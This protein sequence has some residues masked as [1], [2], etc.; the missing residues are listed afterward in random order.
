MLAQPYLYCWCGNV[1]TQRS[2]VI[3]DALYATPWYE[4]DQRYKRTLC[5]AMECMKRPI[6]FKT[7]YYIPL[8]RP[9]FVSILR[10]SYS[11][12]AVL[13]QANNQ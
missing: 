5:I 8:S 2:Q 4:Q 7:G 6:I 9:T 3:R 13:N 11:Y 12:F 10:C 1:V